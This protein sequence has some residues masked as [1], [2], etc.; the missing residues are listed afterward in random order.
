MQD[1]SWPSLR[2]EFMASLSSLFG[3]SCAV[4]F[5]LRKSTGEPSRLSKISLSPI[6]VTTMSQEYTDLAAA[7]RQARTWSVAMTLAVS[8][9]CSSSGSSGSSE[10]VTLKKLRSSKRRMVF[11]VFTV[12]RSYCLLY[13]CSWPH[14]IRSS[15]CTS[16]AS[17]C[18]FARVDS[19]I[20]R[21]I[22][23]SV[24]VCTDHSLKDGMPLRCAPLPLL[25][26]FCAA[27]AWKNGFCFWPRMPSW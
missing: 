10:V 25:L 19:M 26:P 2:G 18:S 14:H 22:S 7:M 20:S 23:H 9:F 16:L 4:S 8:S 15:T 11:S 13:S 3:G 12:V 17:T 27:L 6:L 24:F 5:T 21:F 1:A